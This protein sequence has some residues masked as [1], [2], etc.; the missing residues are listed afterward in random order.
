MVSPYRNTKRKD[1]VMMKSPGTPRRTAS[2]KL[3]TQS[4]PSLNIE[5][6]VPACVGGYILGYVCCWG[7]PVLLC[8]MMWQSRHIAGAVATKSNTALTCWFKLS[9]KEETTFLSL[10]RKTPPALQN[11]NRCFFLCRWTEEYSSKVIML[12]MRSGIP[13][14]ESKRFGGYSEWCRNQDC[15]KLIIL[16]IK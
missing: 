8:M 1:R 15:S 5:T 2:P 12:Y 13:Q 9:F 16:S 14:S 3:S 6:L 10:F 11:S 4:K 7:G